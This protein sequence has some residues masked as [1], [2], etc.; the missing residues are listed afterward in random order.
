MTWTY[1]QI[2]LHAKN[3]NNNNRI[4]LADKSYWRQVQLVMSQLDGLVLGYNAN[5]P[6][7]QTLSSVDLFLLNMMGDLDDL[8]PALRRKLSSKNEGDKDRVSTLFV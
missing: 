6:S 4:P 7:N 2:S 5:C 3:S 8:I 1:E